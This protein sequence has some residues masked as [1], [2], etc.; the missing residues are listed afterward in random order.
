MQELIRFEC[1]KQVATLTINRPK[2][3][4]SLSEAAFLELKQALLSLHQNQDIKLVVLRGEG[5][6]FCAGGDIGFFSRIVTLPVAE[7]A[8]AVRGYIGLAHEVV[9]LLAGLPVPL[10]VVVQ[11]AAAGFGLSLCCLADLLVVTDNSRF[12]P[13][14]IGL[15]ATP[16]GGLSLT[17]PG[18]IGRGRATQLLLSNSSFDAHQAESWGLASTVIA[19]EELDNTVQNYAHKIAENPGTAVSNTLQ[20]LKQKQLAELKTRLQHELES[21][22]VCAAT[23]D[24]EEGVNAFTNQRKPQFS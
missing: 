7:R 10:M 6:A 9:E 20:L 22:A 24:F 13:A 23:A 17:L 8:D 11:G 5:K 12:V 1:D 16:D 2:E 14:Y 3:L 4:N 19:A 18:K 15:G 21:F